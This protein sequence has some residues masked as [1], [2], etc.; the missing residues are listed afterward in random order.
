MIEMKKKR[1]KKISIETIKYSDNQEKIE[2]FTKLVMKRLYDEDV[3]VFFRDMQET[4]YRSLFRTKELPPYSIYDW[5]IWQ[6]NPQCS[7]TFHSKI[8]EQNGELPPHTWDT[9]VHEVTHKE[10]GV[11]IRLGHTKQF[12][13]LFRKNKQKVKDIQEQ[14]LTDGKEDVV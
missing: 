14:F 5:G 13:D 2:K 7:I 1:N 6:K 9:I 11:T 8:F 10:I 3:H 12:N 4:D